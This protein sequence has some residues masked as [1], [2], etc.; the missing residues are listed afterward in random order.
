MARPLNA[1]KK[2]LRLLAILRQR[3]PG[4]PGN[5]HPNPK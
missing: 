3:Q 4:N 5:P 1:G 2:T